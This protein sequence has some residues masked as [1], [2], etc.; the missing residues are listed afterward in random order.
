MS[1]MSTLS[2][3]IPLAMVEAAEAETME[4]INELNYN[5]IICILKRD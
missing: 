1:R 5:V 4:T 2:L 3:T